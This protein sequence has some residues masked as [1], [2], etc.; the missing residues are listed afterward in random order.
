M[1]YFI[2]GHRGSGKSY[3]A[4]QIKEIINCNLFDT[5]PIIRNIYK[6]NNNNLTFEQW[7]NLGIRNFGENFTNKLICEN[8]NLDINKISIVV[9]NRS[10]VGIKYIIDYF[11]INDYKICFI[12]GDVNLFKNN[13][14]FR[15]NLNVNEYE[16]KEIIENEKNMG[17]DNI[18]KFTIENSNN[19][20]YFYK[21]KNDNTIL[22]SI[23]INIKNEINKQKIKQL[24]RK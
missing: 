12:D 9:G 20:M 15:E 18:K 21:T 8:M 19:G 16:F 2:C 4:K 17:I 22:N 23:L 11:N 7:I 10:L 24:K 14:N 5:G 1:V 3:V 13:Y 6:N